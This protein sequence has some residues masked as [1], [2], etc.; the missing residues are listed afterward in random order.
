MNTVIQRLLFLAAVGF[1]SLT[2]NVAEAAT[3]LKFSTWL[4]PGHF[5]QKKILD[6]WA[7]DVAEATDGRVE[8]QMTASALG[9]PQRQFDIVRQGIADISWGVPAYTP[10]RF[11]TAEVLDL[12]FLGNSAEALSVAQWRAQQRFFSSAGEYKDVK[13]LAL[14]AQPPGRIYTDTKPLGDVSDL[15]GLKIRVLTPATAGMIKALGGA[16]VSAASSKT[17]ELL[18]RGIID[19]TF[20]SSDAIPQFK[21]MDYVHHE[22]SVDGG[23]YNACFFLIMNKT[24][25]AS[26]SAD[27]RQ[28]IDKLSGEAFAK[29]IGRIW[30]EQALESERL[31]EEAGV[32]KVLVQGAALESLRQQIDGGEQDWIEAVSKLGVDGE[33]A[34][35]FIREQAASYEAE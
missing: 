29:R 35:K 15:R 6:E 25:W 20:F 27:D 9:P 18:S 21:L 26:L 13:L 14:H 17:Y 22:M 11:V 31:L 7:D 24:K 8:V 28:A 1:T 19:G 2:A 12:P 33:G 23:F 5:V 32:E 3:V 10:G 34:I 16:P 30:D 4:P